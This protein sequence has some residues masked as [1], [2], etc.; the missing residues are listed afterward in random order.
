MMRKHII[1]LVIL[2]NS[3]FGSHLE[4][5]L[6]NGGGDD[7]TGTDW[8]YCEDTCKD[9]CQDCSVHRECGPTE[10]KCGEGPT[11]V[12]DNGLPLVHCKKDDICVNDDCFC[13]F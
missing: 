4:R 1:T 12:G 11:K 13:K 7:N 9:T 2:S 3:V 10:K 8:Q 6:L 5:Q